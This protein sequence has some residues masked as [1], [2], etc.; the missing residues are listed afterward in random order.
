VAPEPG[1]TPTRVFSAVVPS[2]RVPASRF[3]SILADNGIC[4]TPIGTGSASVVNPSG[5]RETVA[6]TLVVTIL[7]GDLNRVR[8]HARLCGVHLVTLEINE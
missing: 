3:L 2:E 5:R 6:G 1:L 7:S 8:A 4:V